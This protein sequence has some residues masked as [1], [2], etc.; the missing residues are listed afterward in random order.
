MYTVI[1]A[2]IILHNMIVEDEADDEL[3]NEHLENNNIA[4]APVV[5]DGLEAATRFASVRGII[6]DEVEHFNLKRDLIEHLWTRHGNQ[7]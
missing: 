7:A 4:V 5:H 3:N 6:R 2:C 1:V